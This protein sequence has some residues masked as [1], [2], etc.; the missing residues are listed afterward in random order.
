M[1]FVVPKFIRRNTHIILF[2][3]TEGF[4]LLKPFLSTNGSQASKKPLDAE[5]GNPKSLMRTEE[6]VQ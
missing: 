4:S 5:N 3:L 1:D 6:N 2:I